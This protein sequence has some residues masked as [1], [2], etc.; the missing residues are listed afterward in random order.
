[1]F[2]VDRETFLRL[3]AQAKASQ[4]QPSPSNVTDKSSIVQSFIQSPTSTAGPGS[5]YTVR[6]IKKLKDLNKSNLIDVN[7]MV[8]EVVVANDAVEGNSGAKKTVRL[9]GI[10]HKQQEETKQ[11]ADDAK[12]K[13]VHNKIVRKNVRGE[14]LSQTRVVHVADD[15]DNYDDDDDGPSADSGS[16]QSQT[17]VM[18]AASMSVDSIVNPQTATT[19]QSQSLISR[20]QSEQVSLS[21]SQSKQVLLSSSQPQVIEDSQSKQPSVDDETK[22]N[23]QPIFR[24]ITMNENPEFFHEEVKSGSPPSQ[25]A[26][27]IT[28]EMGQTQQKAEADGLV[29]TENFSVCT[30]PSASEDQQT[31][32]PTPMSITKLVWKTSSIME[33]SSEQD[34]NQSTTQLYGLEKLSD[35]ASRVDREADS[36]PPEEVMQ[37]I[38]TIMK[39]EDDK[40]PESDSEAAELQKIRRNPAGLYTCDICPYRTRF[41]GMYRR[42]LDQAHNSGKKFKCDVCGAEFLYRRLFKVH[43]NTHMGF[44]CPQCDKMFS[45]CNDRDR[46]IK[47]IH[48]GK[49]SYPFC[50]DP[51][52]DID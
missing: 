46:H 30:K 33:T 5:Q 14:V 48:A 8:K 7:N 52:I 2:A 45:R 6:I 3:A 51:W 41:L 16:S 50:K 21:S 27:W 23:I 13:M 15:G 32:L 49:C 17:D 44:K 25:E 22:S 26:T 28:S 20:S 36:G 34:T 29:Q 12:P 42:H 35:I 1:M 18:V 9:I 11:E 40:N 24:I 19:A 10:R 47:Q 4:S 38:D 31:S 43:M 39:Y 37:T